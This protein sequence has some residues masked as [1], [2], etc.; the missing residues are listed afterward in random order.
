M[1]F[2]G[3]LFHFEVHLLVFV[4]T[5]LALKLAS[6]NL[7]LLLPQFILEVF[8]LPI[9]S[10]ELVVLVDFQRVS[11]PPHRVAL[12][13]SF[14]SPTLG[15]LQVASQLFDEVSVPAIVALLVESLVLEQQFV[16]LA[17]Q[18]VLDVIHVLLCFVFKRVQLA[19]RNV[20]LSLGLI[21]LV[22]QPLDFR[23][24]LIQLNS[25]P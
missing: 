9:E 25:V 23:S 12:L 15:L 13:V 6:L 21:V 8:D 24:L 22:L 10:N 20:Q 18:L 17:L 7:A 5:R 2:V 16:N 4:S 11:F 1:N 14:L 19:A 3:F